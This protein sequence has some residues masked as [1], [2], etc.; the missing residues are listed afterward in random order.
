MLAKAVDMA[1]REDG[2]ADIS[3]VGVSLREVSPGFMPM[4][5][6]NGRLGAL[7][8][9]CSAEVEIK[10]TPCTALV[11]MREPMVRSSQSA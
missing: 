10:R 11:R 1:K 4:R 7:I 9:S 2:W 3:A 8:E 5:Y 6:G